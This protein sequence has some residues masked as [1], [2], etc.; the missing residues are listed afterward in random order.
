[1][2][3]GGTKRKLDIWSN[4]RSKIIKTIKFKYRVMESLFSSNDE[5]NYIALPT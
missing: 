1:M 5:C 3:I 4:R 2:S